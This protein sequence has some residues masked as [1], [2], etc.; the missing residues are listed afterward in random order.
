MDRVEVSTVLYVPQ[1]TVYEFL[2]EFPRYA[3]Y[4][5]YLREVRPD[6][7][8]S[9][10][11]RYDLV[12]AWWKL[13]YTARSEVTDVDPPN[14]IDWRLVKDIDAKGYWQVEPAPDAVPEGTEHAT[15]VRCVVEF[16]PSSVDSGLVDLPSLVSVNWL[17]GKVIPKIRAEAERIVQRIAADLEG[18][19]R[20]VTLQVH[21][22]PDSV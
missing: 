17:L 8:G 11:T 1:E 13:T 19:R 18:T 10:G 4:S 16:D 21:E 5:K 3:K 22:T 14:R 6:G 12:F 2:L 7:D 15:R 20:D 9:P